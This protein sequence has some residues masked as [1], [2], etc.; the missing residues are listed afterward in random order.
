MTWPIWF[1]A[2]RSRPATILL[3]AA[4]LRLRETPR[5]LE[6]ASDPL[7]R[8]L[9][10]MERAV[11]RDR[12]KMTA[13]VR[14]REIEAPDGARFVA[15]FEPEHYI[16]ELTA[17]FF[18]DRFASMR[19]AILTPRTSILWDGSFRFGPG[20][21][22]EDAPPLDDFAGAWDVY[23]RSIFNPARLMKR[24]MLKEMPKK[25]W[26]NL[27]ET[28]Q[29]PAMSSAAL[30][31]ET[32]MVA[33]PPSKVE[34]GAVKSPHASPK[35]EGRK[36]PADAYETLLEGGE[37]L[38]PLFP[39]RLRD[40][41]RVRRRSDAGARDLRWRAARGSRGSSGSSLRR[42]GGR[43]C[44]ARLYARRAS[45]R[46]SAISRTRSSISSSFRAESGAFTRRLARARSII[47]AGGWTRN[48]P[49]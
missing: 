38:S 22:R 1:A 49:W 44:C 16:E 21:L 33:A 46:A 26:A 31:R 13:F 5:F 7:V 39:C 47:A 10:D 29:I 45:Q 24:A 41:N 20:A 40:A 14:F 32:Q 35:P 37:S 36:R 4:L 30:L 28:R 6:I 12:H 15:W 11:R 42:A 2:I 23:Y 19:F 3:Y 9:E 43:D 8:R 27:P 17:P 48:S 25:Y 18:V 34:P